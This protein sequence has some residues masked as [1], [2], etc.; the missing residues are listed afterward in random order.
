MASH[1]SCII[2]SFNCKGFKHRNYKYL[3]KIYQQVDFLLLQETWLY[4][5]EF[6]QFNKVLLD[7]NFVAKSGMNSNEIVNGRPY[8]GTAII[9]KRNS[10]FSVKSIDTVSNRISACM[11][12]GDNARFL[13]LNV[14][15]PTND[16]KNDL[17]IDTLHEIVS[18]CLMFDSFNIILGGDFNCQIGKNDS[19]EHLFKEFLDILELKCLTLDDRFN[20]PYTFINSLTQTS[21]IDHFIVDTD[22]VDKV[23]QLNVLDEGDNLSDHLPLILKFNLNNTRVNNPIIHTDKI[24]RKFKICWDNATSLQK[25]HY[26]LFLSN[27]IDNTLN[28]F[29]GFGCSLVNCRDYAHYNIFNDLL[30]EL[31]ESIELASFACIPIKYFNKSKKKANLMIGWNKYI[32]E[33]RN[34]SIFWHN[35]WKDCGRP[36][37]G[38]V[39][40]IRKTTRKNYHEAISTVKRNDNIIL[41]DQIANSLHSYNPKEFWQH[42]NKLTSSRQIIANEIDGRVGSD[43]CDVFRDKYKLLYNENPSDNLNNFLENIEI[44]INERCCGGNSPSHLHV[45]ESLMVKKA[46]SKLNKGKCD[47]AETLYTDSFIYAPENIN[48]YLAEVFTLMLSHGFLAIHLILLSS[49]L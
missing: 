2:S 21:V 11:V 32:E 25:E 14:Y 40:D 19:R 24:N 48:E 46:I 28:R 10:R 43:A 38:Y 17:F 6:D 49:H 3:Q 4:D 16:G 7:S 42:M 33:Y 35:I 18:L 12:I 1:H 5:Y 37:E 8:S 34:K 47:T 31:I 9:W 44:D 27:L 13:L 39:A 15:M 26:K 23:Y 22:I 29:T 30:S 20:I 36:A 41:R 45:V